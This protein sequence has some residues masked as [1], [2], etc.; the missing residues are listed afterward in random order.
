MRPEQHFC[1]EALAYEQVI[2]HNG[3][4]S[5]LFKRVAE[6]ARGSACNFIDFSIVP[7]GA[8]IGLHTHAT[9]NEEIYIVVSGR[10]V[11]HLDGEEFEVGPG[12]VIVNRPGGTHALKNAGGAELRLVVVEVPT[13]NGPPEAHGPAPAPCPASR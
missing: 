9:D 12:H 3:T 13:R 6:R 8:D 2:A 7:P 4:L 5:I 11:M 1:F 10:G